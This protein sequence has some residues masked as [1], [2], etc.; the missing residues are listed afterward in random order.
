MTRADRSGITAPT[1]RVGRHPSAAPERHRSRSRVHRFDHVVQRQGRHAHRGQRLHLHPGAIGAAHRRGD[2]DVRLTD[3]EIDVDAGQ[4]QLM[5]QRNQV[6]GALGG[7][8]PAT[9]AVASASPLASPPAAISSI[10]CRGGA[11]RACGNR[12]AFGGCLLGD[13]DHMSR[14]LIVDVRERTRISHA[15]HSDRSRA[16][17]DP[18]SGP[19]HRRQFRDLAGTSSRQFADARN[20]TWCDPGGR[21]DGGAGGGIENPAAKLALTGR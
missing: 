12:G 2:V 13:V 16:S 9:R 20:C 1:F 10:T 5:T 11:Q 17:R 6:A 8:N 18:R 15:S 21:G 14:A 7:Q 3:G 19:A 4:R